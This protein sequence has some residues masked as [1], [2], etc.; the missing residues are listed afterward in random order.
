MDRQPSDLTIIFFVVI[1]IVLLLGLLGS[2]Y[3]AF[4]FSRDAEKK[5]SQIAV[6]EGTT[7]ALSTQASIQRA[8]LE[9]TTQAL[10]TQA[11]IQRAQL[12]EEVSARATS[13]AMVNLLNAQVDEQKR[14]L[15]EEAHARATAEAVAEEILSY[16]DEGLCAYLL[17][18]F[19]PTPIYFDIE[20]PPPRINEKII[21]TSYSIPLQEGT[22]WKVGRPDGPSASIE[23]IL[24]VLCNVDSL[25]I[26]FEGDVQIFLDNVNLGGAIRDD[27][28][29]CTDG[30]WRKANNTSAADC[31]SVLGNPPGSISNGGLAA[32]FY[33]PMRYLGDQSSAYGRMLSLDVATGS[34]EALQSAENVVISPASQPGTP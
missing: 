26:Q 33:A 5:A 7:Q 22:G 32:I 29:D 4:S 9:G 2:A 25:A 34:G 27:F 10:S 24:S 21:F 3:I 6:L 12:E 31:N 11:S 28:P 16:A 1:S 18:A 17:E 14:Q 23:E 13:E 20:E 19:T 15:E 8:Q 30:G